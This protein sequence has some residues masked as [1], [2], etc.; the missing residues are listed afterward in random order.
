MKKR[1]LIL[2]L[3]FFS[4]TIVFSAQKKKSD[5]DVN[6]EFNFTGDSEV[7]STEDELEEVEDEAR[8]KTKRIKSKEIEKDYEDE[9]EYEEKEVKRNKKKIR[10]KKAEEYEE[11]E[12]VTVKERDSSK[13]KK[14]KFRFKD[15]NSMIKMGKNLTYGGGASLI[16]G[17]IL[18][19]IG[20]GTA[21]GALY[22]LNLFSN[23]SNLNNLSDWENWKTVFSNLSS[24][25]K[26]AG[27]LAATCVFWSLGGVLLLLSFMMIPGIIIWGRGVHLDNK[28]KVTMS[29]TG[30]ENGMALSIKF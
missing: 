1:V 13:E 24:N 29:L 6:I 27:L 17:S 8:R 18:I 10:E 11:D 2:T 21:I 23:L 5:R 9:D 28:K 25:F 22:S 4:L 20:A 3:L 16:F 7:Y 26:V 19:G 30:V 12:V 15:T 14:S